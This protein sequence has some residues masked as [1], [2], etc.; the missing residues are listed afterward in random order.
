[1][2]SIRRLLGSEGLCLFKGIWTGCFAVLFLVPVIR[3]D[4]EILR[5][6]FC[7]MLVLFCSRSYPVNHIDLKDMSALRGMT[8]TPLFKDVIPFSLDDVDGAEM[9]Y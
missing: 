1:M 5:I 2:T 9:I 8:F 3:G 7:W 6:R 4:C